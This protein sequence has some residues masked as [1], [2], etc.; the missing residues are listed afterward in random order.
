MIQVLCTDALGILFTE[1]LNPNWLNLHQY[2]NVWDTE[3]TTAA[4]HYHYD[5]IWQ[6]TDNMLNTYDK[7]MT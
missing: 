7:L 4:R 2:N 5:L 3:T 1:L 6:F